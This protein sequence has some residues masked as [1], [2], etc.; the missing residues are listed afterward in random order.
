M[1]NPIIDVDESEID[2]LYDLYS[3]TQ[4]FSIFLKS[5]LEIIKEYLNDSLEE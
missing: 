3:V 4:K 1:N 2:E 5:L